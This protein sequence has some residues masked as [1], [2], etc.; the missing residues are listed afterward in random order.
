MTQAEEILQYMR[1]HG[2]ITRLQSVYELGIVNTPGRI[3]D[4]EYMGHKIHRET[5]R[6]E[7]KNGRKFRYTVWSLITPAAPDL[8]V[9]RSLPHAPDSGGGLTLF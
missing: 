9:S 3:K 2:S 7:A 5:R 6:G 8:S 4:L 1:R